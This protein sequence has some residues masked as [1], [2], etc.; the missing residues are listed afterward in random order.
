MVDSQRRK[1]L[2]VLPLAFLP[3]VIPTLP[4][5]AAAATLIRQKGNYLLFIDASAI[6]SIEDLCRPDVL[7]FE[8]GSEVTIVPLR[9]G[10]G[11]SVT[12]AVA[13]WQVDGP[14]PGNHLK[15]DVK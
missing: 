1:M 5:G 6:H 8:K 13:L 2:Q 3:V 4:E 9:L 14:T 10:P 15:A 12:D 11:Q 7:P